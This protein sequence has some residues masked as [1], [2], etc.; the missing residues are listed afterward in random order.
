MV[1]AMI[2]SPGAWDDFQ[3]A[4]QYEECARSSCRVERR[5][6]DDHPN[7]C[8]CFID[9]QQARQI[10][11]WKR[12]AYESRVSTRSEREQREYLKQQREYGHHRRFRLSGW[13]Y[14]I[15]LLWMVFVLIVRGVRLSL[16]AAW[17]VLRMSAIGTA[18]GCQV[19]WWILTGQ[20]DPLELAVNEATT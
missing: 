20:G 13:M 9:E 10:Q 14:E 7:A 3:E 8:G 15:S 19:W 12:E 6:H 18:Y 1:G 4:L 5:H 16:R 11:A 2:L 17:W